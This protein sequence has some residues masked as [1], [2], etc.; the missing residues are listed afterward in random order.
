MID[1]ARSKP[2]APGPIDWRSADA[3]A[4]PFPSAS[5][6]AVTCQFGLM[7]VPDKPAAFREARRV[8]LQGGL[9]VFNV[10]GRMKDNAFGRIAYET[11]G[12]FFPANPPTFYQ[13]PFGFCDP[14]VLRPLLAG[15]GFDR[16]ELDWVTLEARSPSAKSFATGLVEGNPVSLD[17][18]GRGARLEPIIDAVAAALARA[19]GDAPF[20][21]PIR[22]LVVTARASA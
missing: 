5:F 9:F 12:G 20:T 19:G 16:V 6:G 13:V 2:A 18:Q 4:L 14:D 15:N 21:S 17:L 1:Y 22:A 10:W 8:L 11:I 7:F 3:A